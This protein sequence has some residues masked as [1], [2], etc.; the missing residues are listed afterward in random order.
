MRFVVFNNCLMKDNSGLGR[1]RT[2]CLETWVGPVLH[3]GMVIPGLK[4]KKKSSVL[5][6]V[7]SEGW[8]NEY[9]LNIFVWVSVL[10][11]NGT[12]KGQL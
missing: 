5:R 11:R 12:L 8:G 3:F 9:L 10:I 2:F 6:N 1:E 7:Y 4:K